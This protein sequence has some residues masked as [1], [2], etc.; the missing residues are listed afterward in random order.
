MNRLQELRHFPEFVKLSHSVF[1]MPF[2]LAALLLA[3]KGWPSLRTLGL[4]MAAVVLART[5]GMAFNRVVDAQFDAA[6]PRT[7]N[8]HLPS[9]KISLG[10]AC[11]I[12]FIATGG[13]VVVSIG[14]G[15]LAGW[16][17]P[18]ALLFVLG[19][20]WTKRFTALSHFVLGIALGLAPVGAWLAVK[21]SLDDRVPWFIGFA[22]VLWVA[23]FDILYALQDME[24]DRRQGLH[25]M[26]V[27]LGTKKSL[28]LVR[29]LHLLMGLVLVKVGWISSLPWPYFAGLGIVG[30]FL[31]WEH[32]LL[33]GLRPENLQKAFLQANAGT[34]FGFLAAVALGVFAGK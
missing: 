27:S 17:S 29:I 28:K 1:A 30:A 2:A 14:I 16:L 12:V 21:G 32:W 22:V 5:A 8:R 24:F 4:V 19:Y 6:N 34:S 25:S 10:T 31:L 26:V 7:K 11:G 18:I 20:S 15:P 33:R 23:G 13:F 3:S 9:G